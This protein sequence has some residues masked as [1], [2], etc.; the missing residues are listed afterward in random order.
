MLVVITWLFVG[1]LLQPVLLAIAIA[2]GILS[3]TWP[4]ALAGGVAAGLVAFAVSGE[5]LSESLFFS[6][7]I[8]AG[9]C[10]AAVTFGI[11]RQWTAV[12]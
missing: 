11:K 6:L 3:R 8:L 12:S 4:L 5:P 7:S 2:A 10:A 1:A 9:L